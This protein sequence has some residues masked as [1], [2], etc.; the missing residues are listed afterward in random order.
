MISLA[1]RLQGVGLALLC[2]LGAPAAE[3]VLLHFA[4]MWH[5]PQVRAS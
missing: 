2:G 1:R 5:Y 3:V 4:P